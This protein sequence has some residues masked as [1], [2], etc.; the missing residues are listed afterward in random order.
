MVFF[1]DPVPIPD[2]AE[3]AVRMAV[4][5]REAAGSLSPPGASAASI[6]DLASVSL[7]VT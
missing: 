3:R 1:N 6:W 5:M 2:P 4:A 7:S